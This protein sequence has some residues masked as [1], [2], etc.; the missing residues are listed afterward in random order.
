MENNDNLVTVIVTL[1][2]KERYIERCLRS[3]AGQSYS[4]LEIFVVNDGS[5]DNSLLK[6]KQIGSKD[7]R[8][9]II[10]KKNGGL[11]SARNYGIKLAHGKEIIFIDGD[12]YI[13]KE[14]ISNLMKY[15]MYDLVISGFYESLNGEKIKE[16]KPR[17]QVIYKDNFKDYVFNSKHYFY[18]V[19]AWNKLFQ[20]SIIKKNKLQ[21]ENIVMGEDAD[22]L[23][24]YLVYC[25]KIKIIA[26]ANYCNVIIP[27]TLSRKK[28]DNLWQ[29]N[30]EVV[31]SAQ[32]NLSLSKNNYAFLILRSI[33][34]TLGGNC[35]RYLDFKASFKEI[36]RSLEIK[37]ISIA[38]ISERQN[39]LIYIG[40]KMDLIRFLQVLF[41]IKTKEHV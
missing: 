2:N 41:K 27:N 20:T 5:T 36:K 30:L 34:V 18:C 37:N 25:K 9:N 12:D 32:R 33:K 24:K 31:D 10:D 35:K 14:Y 6:A 13:D 38:N 4:N 21:F 40:I 8:F 22:F 28:V 3:I 1:Y 19:L 23:F 17:S 26:K 16:C 7:E 15:S 11:S 29:H 39:A